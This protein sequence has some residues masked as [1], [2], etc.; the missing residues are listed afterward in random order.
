MDKQLRAFLQ[1]AKRKTFASKI[2]IPKPTKRGGKEYLY[3]KGKFLYLDRYYGSELDSGQ[4]LVFYEKNLI[5][6]MSYRGAC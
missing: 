1:I 4:E 6:S 3:E 2:S 5:W